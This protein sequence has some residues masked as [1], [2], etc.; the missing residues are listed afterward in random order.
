MG[1]N[2]KLFK[3]P[4][5]LGVVIL[6]TV[7]FIYMKYNS[8]SNSNNNSNIYNIP[9]PMEEFPEPPWRTS[10][11]LDARTVV[12]TPF[13]RFEVHKVK[14]ESGDI[15]NDWLWTDERSHVNILVS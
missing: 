14:T 3:Y 6:V 11:T 4:L 5:I 9:L 8:N 2:N 7:Y 12:S 13:A 10:S 1:N 15:V